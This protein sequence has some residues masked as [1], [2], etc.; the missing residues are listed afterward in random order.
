[1]S[2][3]RD[4]DNG[5]FRRTLSAFDLTMLGIGGII[6]TGI[7]VLTG[8]AAA[9]YA[10]PAIVLSFIIAGV[11]AGLA[12]MCYSELASMVP[13]SGSAYT[14]TYATMG[15]LLAWIIGWDLVLEYLVGAATVA[16]G[17]SGYTVAFFQSIGG[18]LEPAASLWTQPPIAFNATSGLLQ[19]SGNYLN[20]PAIGVVLLI[21]CI[22]IVGIKE[23]VRFNLTTVIT[24]LI[25]VFLFIGI[26]IPYLKHDN[27][28]PFIPPN[29]S[30]QFGRFGW[31]GILQASSLVFFSYIGFDAVSTTAQECRN[32]QRDLPIGIIGS[33]LICMILYVA[34]CL[35]M[36]GVTPYTTLNVP[37]PISIAVKATGKRWLAVL[38][39][40]GAV[41]GLSS[42]LL[43]TL[44]GQPRI[45]SAM[46]KDGLLPRI[47]A[48]SHPHF[49]TPYV[50]SIISG[51]M[52]AILAG[53]FPVDLLG[54]LTSVGTLF[55]FLLV[56]LAV[57]ILRWRHPSIER[58]F[59]V[60]FGPY[61][62]PLLGAFA[63]LL[64]IVT[65]AG[66]TLIRLFVWLVIGIIIYAAYGYRHSRIMLDSYGRTDD[67]PLINASPAAESGFENEE[68][69]SG[70]DNGMENITMTG[71]IQD[72][73]M[74]SKR[75]IDE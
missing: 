61:I 36:T 44:M 12:A 73:T 58:K 68:L 28:V 63:C 17:W 42:V 57:P 65:T 55:A 48:Q 13:L 3:T 64:L 72:L 31:S 2:I 53:I 39:E 47:F 1:M 24:K 71:D 38:V 34:T 7:F 25:V 45:L 35:C 4:L 40:F 69:E 46:S 43:V 41:A 70:D 50:S 29:T 59:T 15:E 60:P 37:H 51:I 6:G 20:L 30:G 23:S 26:S 11:V 22:L 5:G 8:H 54:E 33:L 74:R 10:G 62:I 19:P 27:W 52:C 32:P 21:T 18:S 75:L 67:F 9:Q 66:H 14:Y 16:V 49:K 56:C